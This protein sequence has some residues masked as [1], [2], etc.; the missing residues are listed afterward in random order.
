MIIHNLKRRN[1]TSN[2]TLH[3]KNSKTILYFY[4][5][6]KKTHERPLHRNPCDNIHALSIECAEF[7][8][9]LDNNT[10]NI[11]AVVVGVRFIRHITG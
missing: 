2:S 11:S 3:L 4:L 1:H 9:A 10:G 7:T 5:I 8:S 6:E